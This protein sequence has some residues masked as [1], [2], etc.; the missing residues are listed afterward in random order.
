V[1]RVTPP[2][3]SL[4]SRVTAPELS[5]GPTKL[6][7]SRCRKCC[8]VSTIVLVY[9]MCTPQ[10][11]PQ[12]QATAGC[13]HSQVNTQGV[14]SLKAMQAIGYAKCS[15]GAA[16]CKRGAK[17]LLTGTRDAVLDVPQESQNVLQPYTRHLVADE[18]PCL[19]ELTLQRIII[20][21]K[22]RS[23]GLNHILR[24]LIHVRISIYLACQ[25]HSCPSLA[26]RCIIKAF[27]IA[28]VLHGLESIDAL[29]MLPRCHE[30]A[31]LGNICH[32]VLEP[33]LLRGHA[34]PQLLLYLLAQI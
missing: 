20:G 14:N 6:F 23:V 8:C 26:I 29:D 19:V 3:L 5:F 25:E 4:I 16:F 22:V 28:D 34:C 21:N 2:F 32:L 27:R 9:V 15:D 11:T 30:P 12:S 1:S 24:L 13:H 17:M 31:Q 7:V 18:E 10:C 33:D